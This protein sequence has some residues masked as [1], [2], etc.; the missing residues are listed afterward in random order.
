MSKV[1]DRVGRAA[2]LLGLVA[3]LGFGA[4]TVVSASRSRDCLCVPPDN[5]FC[6]RC[7][8][9][10]GSICPPTGTEPRECLCA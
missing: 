6:E 4:Q 2:F 8:D 7:C 10:E 3:A 9:A 5:A 1:L